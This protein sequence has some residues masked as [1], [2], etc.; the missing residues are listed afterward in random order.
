[1][2]KKTTDQSRRNF[3]KKSVPATIGA[4]G[5]GTLLLDACKPKTE[6][7]DEEKVSLLSPDGKLVEVSKSAVTPK[8]VPPEEAREGI[9]GKKFVMVIDLA[10]CKNAR[11]CVSQ[12][13]EMHNLPKEDEWIKVFLMQDSN[14]TAP[15]WFPKP[16]FH[17]NQPPCVKVCP[18]G[19]TFKRTDGIVLI[20]T[21]RCIGCKFCM[22]ACPYSSRVFQWKEPEQTEEM[23]NT[24]YSPETSVPRRVGT[25]GKCD[26]CPDMARQGKLPACVTGCPNGTIFFGDKN[27]DIVTNGSE[28]FRFSELVHDR[29][30]YHF[31]AEL[32]TEPNVYYL[33]PV[34][35]LFD[36]ESGFSSLSEEQEEF[37][38][39]SIVHKH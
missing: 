20:D 2:E 23:C 13:Q 12:C 4:I 30:G 29:A 33:P 35:R 22:T 38:K 11:Q 1:M 19:A 17:C 9:R 31:M 39:K 27:E 10:R 15:Y 36:Y 7:E 3:F 32:G 37:Y 28:T 24:P 14:D 25:V 6:G 16:C 8:P 26:F 34:D 18:V 5:M 21:D